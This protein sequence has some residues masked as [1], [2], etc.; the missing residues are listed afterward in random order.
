MDVDIPI[1]EWYE[2]PLMK[3]VKELLEAALPGYEFSGPLCPGKPWHYCFIA[4]KNDH[5]KVACVHEVTHEITVEE[6]PD[7]G[8]HQVR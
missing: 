8:M 3:G 7:V 1:I 6:L 2:H 5:R 4:R